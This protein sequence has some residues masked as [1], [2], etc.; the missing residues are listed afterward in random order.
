VYEKGSAFGY[1]YEKDRTQKGINRI[2]VDSILDRKG[3]QNFKWHLIINKEPISSREYS[4]GILKEIYVGPN[5]YDKNEN[6]SVIFSYSNRFKEY[7]FSFSKILDSVKGKKLFKIQLLYPE[8][9]S[10]EYK[11]TFPKK[12]TYLEM[13]E[14]RIENPA[15]IQQVF[16]W[17]KQFRKQD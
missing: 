14:G 16:D 4:D 6:D 3:L 9:Y 5:Q 15:E 13:R 11:I 10:T 7:D 1:I 2:S 8:V 12:E 17:Y